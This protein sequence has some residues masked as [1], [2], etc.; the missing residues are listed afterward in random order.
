MPTLAQFAAGNAPKKY[1]R[2]ERPGLFKK[3]AVDTAMLGLR[4][5]GGV[6]D[7]LERPAISLSEAY[8][9][10]VEGEEGGESTFDAW[11]RGLTEGREKKKYPT[12]AERIV[13]EEEDEGY[14]RK[15][16]RLGAEIATDPTSYMG[17]GALTNIG[18]KAIG[19]AASPIA[20]GA[21]AIAS[22]ELMQ[23][24]GHSKAAQSFARMVVPAINH[25]SFHGGG[26]GKAIGVGY[27]V[28]DR[29]RR[30]LVQPF[31][32]D[33]DK[34][35]RRLGLAGRKGRARRS[36][37]RHVLEGTLDQELPAG[38]TRAMINDPAVQELAEITRGSL[39]FLGEMVKEFKDY[40]GEG[41]TM[42][43]DDGSTMPFK[44]R[45]NYFPDMLNQKA[46][47]D[48]IKSS[49]STRAAEKLAK[50]RGIT[51]E[52]ARELQKRYS[53]KV[54][55]FGNIEMP[56]T[57]RM[58]INMREDDVAEVYTRYV[59]EVF[60]RT[61]FSKEFGINLEK[62]VG[63]TLPDTF[64][65]GK[66][67]PGKHTPGLF[68]HAEDF[69]LNKDTI[70]DVSDSIRGIAPKSFLGIEAL[71]PYVMA[72][73][74]LTKLGPTSTLSNLSQQTNIVVRE[75]FGNYL[76]GLVKLA[77][78]DGI[79]SRSVEAVETGI[80][81][82]LQ[83][84]MGENTDNWMSAAATKWLGGVG[85]NL[86]ESANRRVGY[87]AGV[88]AAEQAAKRAIKK[89]GP[90]AKSVDILKADP[91]LARS[92]L[93]GNDLN[94]YRETGKLSPAAERRVGFQAAEATQFTTNYLDLPSA[95]RSPEMKIAFQFKNFVY[96][97]SRFLMR[98]VMGPAATWME[99][100]GKRGTIA[101]LARAMA[102]Y[103]AGGASVAAL[104]EIYAEKAANLTGV[105]RRFGRKIDE[106]HPIW[107]LV[108]DSLYVG[109]MGM[110]GDVL[111]QAKR[112]NLMEWAAGPTGADIGVILGGLEKL[113]QGKPVDPVSAA[114]KF[115]P[116]RRALPLAPTELGRKIQEMR[117]RLKRKSAG[118]RQNLEKPEIGDFR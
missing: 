87:A 116:G 24:V 71:A 113:S 95:W 118:A 106:D 85:F 100:G 96:Q 79:R 111:E 110:A 64:V 94:F 37:V 17:L 21:R 86:A 40:K 28:A 67:I 53:G 107:Q 69:G 84:L 105:E 35:V 81:N 38:I 63:E 97:Q 44:M 74:V 104:R 46:R 93:K 12:F 5:L 76:R 34:H 11:W 25:I 18:K 91:I 68:Q 98:D 2:P 45:K 59:D 103:P 82:Q 109:S 50:E 27:D 99:S 90:G 1:Q 73:Q 6:V 60:R 4:G 117:A 57:S 32:R 66:R 108:Q 58:P 41:F 72:F 36:A 88:A 52:Q 15:A 101:P 114:T 83:D 70:Q 62:L 31:I 65:K 75:G 92:A 55:K 43:M 78:D 56:R 47:Q 8:G 10:V 13:P 80:R 48:V 89:A 112:G 14:G 49:G 19:K 33:F 7:I 29:A 22:T 54:V 23:R 26:A 16:L 39:D 42:L 61:S 102:M 30:K 51:V 9:D 77:R 20:R 3:A 115:I